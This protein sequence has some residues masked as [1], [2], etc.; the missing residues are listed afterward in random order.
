MPHGF[1]RSLYLLEGGGKVIAPRHHHGVARLP[2]IQ[3][4][5]DTSPRGLPGSL[6]WDNL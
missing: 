6:P 4:C 2:L 3:G 5:G 1:P